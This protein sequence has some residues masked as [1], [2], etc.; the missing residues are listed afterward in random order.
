VFRDRLVEDTTKNNATS[1]T[2]HDSA[3]SNVSAKHTIVIEPHE[4]VSP[5]D[6]AELCSVFDNPYAAAKPSFG[7]RANVQTGSFHSPTSHSNHG[8]QYYASPISGLSRKLE[9]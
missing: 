4:N 1:L 7:L 6:F 9:H 8:R 2:K 3:D 5:D